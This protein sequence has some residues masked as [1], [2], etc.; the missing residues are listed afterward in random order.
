M[1]LTPLW[2]TGLRHVLVCDH[3]K[4]STS[5]KMNKLELKKMYCQ[6]NSS[7]VSCDKRNKIELGKT[8]NM[9]S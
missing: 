3:S 5:K 8:W 6:E 9:L 7:L 1:N 2:I 4:L